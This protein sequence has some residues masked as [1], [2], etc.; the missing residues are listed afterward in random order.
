MRREH[1]G[2]AAHEFVQNLLVPL[3][4]PHGLLVQ[5]LAHNQ[6]P[7]AFNSFSKEFDTIGSQ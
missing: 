4:F 5:F 1:A 7:L 6:H 2:G 3:S